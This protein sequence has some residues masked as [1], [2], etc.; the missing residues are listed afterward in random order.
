ML[1]R[2]F[3]IPSRDGRALLT[4]QVDLPADS[5][6]R[7]PTVLMVPGGWFMER[8]GWMGNSG[9]ERDLIYRE[10]ARAFIASGLTVVRFDNRGVRGNEFTMPPCPAGLSE[11][12]AAQHYLQ[13]CINPKVRSTVTVQTQQD[14][15]E[16]VW[17]FTSEHANVDPARI[18]IWAHSEGG[19]NAARLIGAKRIEPRGLIFVGTPTEDPAGLFH[20]QVVERYAE[21]VMTWDADDD[22]LVTPADVEREFPNDSMF[23]AVGMSPETVR[24]LNGHWTRETIFA[25]FAAEYEALKVAALATADDASYPDA[26][27]GLELVAASNNWWKQ[28]FVETTPTIDHLED[29]GGRSSFHLG[30]ID[31]QVPCERQRAL[32]EARI[33]ATHFRNPPSVILHR[34]RGHSLRTGEPAAGPMDDAAIAL[35]VNE[36]KMLIAKH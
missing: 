10:L 27:P 16:D 3:E 6:S 28:W 33:Q 14:D 32:A 11:A 8:D 35:L 22:G 26:A 18:V 5:A 17:R 1:S 34:R 2:P 31:S 9:T 19:L 36:V 20:W 29:Y 25:R 13:S 7:H 30:E 15:I 4:G 21:R 12:E 24:P 23:A